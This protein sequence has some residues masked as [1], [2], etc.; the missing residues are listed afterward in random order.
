MTPIDPQLPLFLGLMSGTSADG[1]DAALVQ[2]PV[3]GGCRFVH[4]HTFDWQVRTRDALVAL[5]QGA[6]PASLD[7]L[8]QLDAEVGIAFA[9]AANGLLERAGIARAQVRA[10]G[11]HGQTIR[12]RPTASPAFTWQI[13]DANRIAELTGITT[14]ADFRRRD[15]AAGGHGAPLMPA[16]H[17]AMLGSSGEDRAV[18]NLGGIAN[19]SLLARDGSLRGFD[20]GP[21]NALLDGWCQRHLGTAFDADGAFA[22]SGRV[23]EAL[24]ARLLD[25]AWF[26][27]PPPKSTGREQ[28]HLDWVDARIGGAPLA[29]ADVQATLLELTATTVTGALLAHLPGVRRLLACGGGVRNTLLLRRIGARLPGVEVVSSAAYGLDPDYME[30]MGFAWLARETLA[31]RPGNLPSVSGARGPRILGAIHPA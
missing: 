31:G 14:V 1:I 7:A 26:A 5:G 8:G 24:L 4:G 21:A 28:F 20:T 10:I 9:A 29:P 19:L 25:D 17:L 27:L 3:E 15:V 11:S 2:F 6:E 13:G 30:A 18:L 23:D 16:F 22:A 12:H